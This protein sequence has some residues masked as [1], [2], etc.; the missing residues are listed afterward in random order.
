MAPV[1]KKLYIDNLYNMV[2][3]HDN[4]YHR[5]H[6]HMDIMDPRGPKHYIFGNQF[7][8]KNAR[9]LRFHESLH[10]YARKHVISSFY[11]KWT[12][13]TRNF[14]FYSNLVWVPEDQKLK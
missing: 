7:C 2:N 1:F 14:E 3:K 13:F 11:Q 10:F 12:K 8:S 9:M 6:I 5:M 4:T